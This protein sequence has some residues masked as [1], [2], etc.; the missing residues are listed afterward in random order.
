MRIATNVILAMSVVLWF[1][2]ASLASTVAFDNL[3]PN[4]SYGSV[5]YILGN[6][7]FLNRSYAYADGFC[8]SSSGNLDELW[9]AM[10]SDYPSDPLTLSLAA[11]DSG[12]P[13]S[14]LWSDTITSQLGQFG[15]ILHLDHLNGPQLEAGCSYWLT[16]E[17][18]STQNHYH[19]WSIDG[20][21]EIGDI[22]YSVNGGQW[23][24][25]STDSQ[26]LGMKVGVVPEP[27]TFGLLAI[28]AIGL[29]GWTQRKRIAA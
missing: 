3:G 2:R 17:G 4:D 22:A 15:T 8:P 7:G 25:S 24:M 21:G 13:G 9:L 1:G 18:P 11:D 14:V 19:S 6:S 23:L 29:L 5:G 26:S 20:T 16:A 28:G 12:L 10:T 27:S